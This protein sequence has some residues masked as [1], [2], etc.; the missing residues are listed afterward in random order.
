M[1]KNDWVKVHLVL[2]QASPVEIAEMFNISTDTVKTA[3]QKVSKQI[4]A[5]ELIFTDIAHPE[6]WE[7]KMKAKRDKALATGRTRRTA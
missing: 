2:Q 7:I 5:G 1:R 6:Q 3:I 4:R